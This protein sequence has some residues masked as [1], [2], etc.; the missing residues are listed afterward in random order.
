MAQG[1]WKGDINFGLVYIPVTLYSAESYQKNVKLVLLDKRDLARVGYERINK[2]TGKK[3]PLDQLVEGYEYK[4]ERYAVISREALK[5][6]HPESTQSITILEFVDVDDIAPEYFEKPYYLEPAK[7]GEHAYALLREA[8]RKTKKV[9]VAKVVIR[10]REYL[11]AIMVEDKAIVLQLM[12]FPET[13]ASQNKFNFPALKSPIKKQEMMV[14]E[15][16]IKKMSRKWNPK[17]YHDTYEKDLADFI[18]EK[19]KLGGKAAKKSP[20]K[21]KRKSAEVID[22]MTLLKKSISKGGARRHP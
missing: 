6:I 20:V 7:K 12:R 9:G 17:K 16:L 1:I 14:A 21:T 15:T 18:K 5:E 11:S 3:V 8:L 13:L 4:D 10:T 2:N 22:I 19:I